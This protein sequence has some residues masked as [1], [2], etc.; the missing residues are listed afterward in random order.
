MIRALNRKV[1]S[2]LEVKQKDRKMLRKICYTI[3]VLTFAFTAV[4]A[5]TEK[6]KDRIMILPFENTSTNAEF[7][8]IGESIAGSLTELLIV[9]DLQVISNQERKI[10]QQRLNIPTSILPS[11]ATSLKLAR[12]GRATLLLSGTYSVIPE[13]KDVAASITIKAKVIRVNEGRFL[14]ETLPNGK[15]VSREINLTDALGN[16]QKLQGQLA[17]QTLYQWDKVLPFAQKQFVELANKVP[18]RAFEAYIKGLLTPTKNVETRANYFK[19]A[20]RIFEEERE[21][22]IY[23]DAALEL[24]HLYLGQNR[25]QN[26]IYFFGKVSEEVDKCKAEAKRNQ[27]VARCDDAS[28]GEATFY[29]SLIYWRQK[30]YELALTIL[31]PLADDLKL[32]S[33]YNTLGAIAVQASRATKRDKNKSAALLVEGLG[34]LKKASESTNDQMDVHFNYA[35]ALFLQNNYKEASEK[36]RPVLA[37][38]QR[39]GEAYFLLAKILEKLG[40]KSAADFD[41][42][43]RRFLT[44][45][46]KYANL[47]SKWKRG[48]FRGLELRIKQPTRKDFVSVVLI[49][50][51]AALATNQNPIDETESLLKQAEN[52]YKE[53]R[54]DSAMDI[55]RRIAVSE[56][57]S[58]KMHLLTGKIFVRRGDLDRAIDSFKAAYFYD[59]EMVESHI[60]LARIYIQ[61]KDCLQAKNYSKSALSINPENEEAMALER[62]VERCS[63]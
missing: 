7:N 36:I 4:K 31:R 11:L 13:N 8:W 5:Q 17:Y 58:A 40:D 59:S 35:L 16:L 54:D 19:N 55:L 14:G 15:R 60:F 21:G 27:R 50:S 47:E 2:Q 6:N 25:R 63:K 30:Q 22:A 41:N 3:L 48:D 33:V 43:A 18:T 29:T 44:Q 10:I 56:P 39:D 42:Q 1:Y 46:N 32:T 23:A 24:G 61:K 38:N 53:G 57:M 12:Q 28:Y 51:R 37:S 34:F 49:N 52:H 45:N 20:M 26:A 9:P 62:Q